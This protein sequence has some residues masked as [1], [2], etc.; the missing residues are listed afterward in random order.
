MKMSCTELAHWS[1]IVCTESYG[2][3]GRGHSQPCLGLPAY[4]ADAQPLSYS[5]SQNQFPST[6]WW[7][8]ISLDFFTHS[9]RIHLLGISCIKPG[10]ALPTISVLLVCCVVFLVVDFSLLYVTFC[11]RFYLEG[12]DMHNHPI[13]QTNPLRA[14]LAV[15]LIF[16]KMAPRGTTFTTLDLMKDVNSNHNR[17]CSISRWCTFPSP[18]WGNQCDRMTRTSILDS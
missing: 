4:K 2:F 14:T 10:V 16:H 15:S 3:S 5:P 11:C 1:S 18:T 12:W 13:V 17:E 9:L 7:A 6:G 8:P